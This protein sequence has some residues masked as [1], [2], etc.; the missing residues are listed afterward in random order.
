MGGT[1]GLPYRLL[2]LKQELWRGECRRNLLAF[3]CQALPASERPPKHHKLICA[4]L[5]QLIR[6]DF[7]RLLIIAP[8]GSAKTTYVSRLFPAHYFASARRIRWN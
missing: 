6:G 8:P 1:L 7:D 2:K 3:A 4:K 5:E